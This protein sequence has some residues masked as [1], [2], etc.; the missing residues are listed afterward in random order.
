MEC[1]AE[2][3][4]GTL[5]RGRN[6]CVQKTR[7]EREGQKPPN[8]IC[9]DIIQVW[10][11]QFAVKVGDK[12]PFGESSSMK[13]QIRLPYPSKTVVYDIYQKFAQ[14]QDCTEHSRPISFSLA[15]R[16]WKPHS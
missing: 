6:Y 12:L 16:L 3:L 15:S 9:I 10:L 8:V 4:I 1:P 5:P 2:Y 14:S 13:M 7:R 11:L